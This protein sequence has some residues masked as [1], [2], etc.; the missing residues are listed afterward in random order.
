MYNALSLHCLVKAYVVYFI[1]QVL[2]LECSQLLL[3]VM[4]NRAKKWIDGMAQECLVDAALH[5]EE[6]SVCL[7]CVR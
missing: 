6:E 3:F 7:K 5:L 2:K 1:C 4:A